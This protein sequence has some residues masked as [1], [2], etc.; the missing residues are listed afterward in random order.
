MISLRAKWKESEVTIVQF[1][2]GDIGQ[3]MAVVI[4][5]GGTILKLNAKEL[6]VLSPVIELPKALLPKAKK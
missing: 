3:L 1:L 2:G 4:S 5:E 6:H